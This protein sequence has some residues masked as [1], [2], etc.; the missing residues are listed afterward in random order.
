MILPVFFLNEPIGRPSLFL[1]GVRPLG[2]IDSSV[3]ISWPMGAM[4]KDG[5][6]LSP[7]RGLPRG[8]LGGRSFSLS[9]SSKKS[10]FSKRSSSAG[11]TWSS[12]FATEISWAIGVMTPST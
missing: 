7:F 8:F 4:S 3:G 12:I 2:G 11:D 5:T 6:I 1:L 9:S 10:W